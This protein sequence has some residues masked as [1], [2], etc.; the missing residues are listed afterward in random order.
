MELT[1]VLCNH[2]EA[3][4][5]LLYVLGGG[6]D[7][8]V[9]PAGRS[10]PFAISLGIGIVVEVPWSATDEQHTVTVE[11]EDADGHQVEIQR[12][13]GER[14][15]F[16]AQFHFNVGRPHHLKDGDTQSVAFALNVPVLPFEEV[17]SY[18]FAIGLDG[19]VARRLHYRL[20]EQA[21]EPVAANWPTGF[22]S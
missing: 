6:I 15:P 17:G 13:P 19:T 2:A 12:G 8:T 3:Q 1:A 18:V 7:R 14:E 20:I 9:I 16:R 21:E 11:L 10:G 22:R 4:N 5:N